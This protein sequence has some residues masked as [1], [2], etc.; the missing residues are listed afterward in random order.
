M[1]CWLLT[2]FQS[3][4][5]SE[6]ERQKKEEEAK[7]NLKADGKDREK[8]KEKEREKGA[9]GS[10]TKGTTTPQGKAKPD[11]LKKGKSLKRPGSPNLSESSGNESSRKKARKQAIASGQGSRATT[12]LPP[13]QAAASQGS[14]AKGAGFMSDGEGTAGEMSDGGKIKKKI[15][16]IGTGAKNSPTGSRA[17]SPVPSLLAAQLAPGMLYNSAFSH[18]I[19]V[20]VWPFTNI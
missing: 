11:A 17:G 18:A 3:E 16:I 12:P 13:S 6:S 5:E 9:S 20:R 4:D 15:K 8:E 19:L 10:S 2:T 7:N 1:S 14:R